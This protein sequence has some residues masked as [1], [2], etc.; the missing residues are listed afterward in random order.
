MIA[1]GT[2][3]N[4]NAAAYT[5]YPVPAEAAWAWCPWWARQAELTVPPEAS[6]TT[7]V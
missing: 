6:R 7:T 2:I 3:T 4:R 5:V 1:W